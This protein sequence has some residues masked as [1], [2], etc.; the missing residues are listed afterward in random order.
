MKRA[1]GIEAILLPNY[2]LPSLVS[3]EEGRFH[4]L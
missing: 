1:S 4:V 3:E 2:V